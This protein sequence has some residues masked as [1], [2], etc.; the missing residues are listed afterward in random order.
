MF[1]ILAVLFI[2]TCLPVL[3]L[4]QDNLS[5]ESLQ[6]RIT[7][8]LATQ[9]GSF[10]VAFKDLSSGRELFIHEHENFHA[11]STMKVPVMIEVFKQAMQKKFSVTDSLV[12][13]NEFISIA[14]S[15]HFSLDPK[16]DSEFELYKQIG[17]KKSIYDL[18][19]QMIILSSN[20]ATN[21]IIQLVDAKNVT[22]TMRSLGAKDIQVLRGVEDQKAFDKGIINTTTAYDLMLILEQVAKGKVV[23]KKACRAMIKILLDQQFNDIIPAKLPA[24]VKVAHKTGWITGLQHDAGIIFLPDGRRYVLVLLSKNL[25]DEKAGVDAMATVSEMIYKNLTH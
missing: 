8:I 2:C 23:S 14:D 5:M 21:M 13:K 6:Q 25:E 12:V 16:D 1:K 7:D 20:F 18:V 11:A 10:A 15:S 4:S 22:A 24:D 9:K 17:Q 3:L 19:Y